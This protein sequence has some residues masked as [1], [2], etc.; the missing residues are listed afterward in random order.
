MRKASYEKIHHF[1]YFPNITMLIQ[2][3]MI[4]FGHVALVGEKRNDYGVWVCKLEQR[5]P[6]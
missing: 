5:E 2:S 3:R 4:W 1:Y 6:L